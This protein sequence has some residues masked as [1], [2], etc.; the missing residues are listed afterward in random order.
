MPN[1]EISLIADTRRWLWRGLA[2][3]FLVLALIGALLPVM[4]TVPFVLAAA[5]AAGKGWPALELHL[6]NH[7]TF[8]Q[9]IRHWREHGAVPRKAKWLACFMMSCSAVMLW[10]LPIPNWLRWSVY[11]TFVVVGLWLCTR[12][13]PPTPA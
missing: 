10:F 12:P 3:L 8:G 13:A 4:P 1:L 11:G 7:P 9:P 2:V 6:L 5:W